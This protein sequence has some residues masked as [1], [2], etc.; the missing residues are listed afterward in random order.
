[1]IVIDQFLQLQRLT[2]TLL[3][4]CRIGFRWSLKLWYDIRLIDIIA[5]VNEV[6]RISRK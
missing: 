4:Y 5:R 3:H 1:L 2:T 6:T